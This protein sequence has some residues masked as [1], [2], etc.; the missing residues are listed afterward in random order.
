MNHR[1][2]N[3]MKR[4]FF[5]LCLLLLTNCAG[6]NNNEVLPATTDTSLL[7]TW[8]L[9]E[10]FTPMVNRRE[11]GDRMISLEFT[12]NGR[13]TDA[14]SKAI[15]RTGTFSIQ[16]D[17]VGRQMVVF[18]EEKV[19]QFYEINKKGQLELYQ[20][21]PLGAELADGQTFIYEKRP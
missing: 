16:K 17:R 11:P 10:V 2:F 19:Y 20:Q 8:V 13:F 1:P 21:A 3:S 14:Y 7:G 12:A 5:W 4:N 15:R 18:E 9:V 6:T